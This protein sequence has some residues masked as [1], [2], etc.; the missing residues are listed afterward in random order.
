[1][2]TAAGIQLHALLE[3]YRQGGGVPWEQFGADMRTGRARVADIG[4]GER[5]SSISIGLT[6]PKVTVAP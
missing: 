4:C 3:A 2:V 1:M 5:W 6:Y